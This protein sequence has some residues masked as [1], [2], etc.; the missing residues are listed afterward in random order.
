VCPRL[1]PGVKRRCVTR[2]GE[3]RE[4]SSEHGSDTQGVA[5]CVATSMCHCAVWASE[6]HVCG[7]DPVS[8][9]SRRTARACLV[10]HTRYR[11]AHTSEHMCSHYEAPQAGTAVG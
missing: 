2:R 1:G 4:Q 3:R 8:T 6:R 11:Y 7:W 9:A 10:K 5:A